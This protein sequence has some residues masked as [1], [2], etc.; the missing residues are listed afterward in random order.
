MQAVI[1]SDDDGCDGRRCVRQRVRQQIVIGVSVAFIIVIVSTV[2]VIVIRS[3]EHQ[4][5]LGRKTTTDTITTTTNEEE[6]EGLN[7]TKHKKNNGCNVLK[8][9]HRRCHELIYI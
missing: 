9:E 7:V 5:E 4:N 6:E 1:D 3:I 8:T 2:T